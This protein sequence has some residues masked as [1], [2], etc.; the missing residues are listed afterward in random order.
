MELTV[1]EIKERIEESE[2]K[3]YALEEFESDE[4]EL[5]FTLGEI[6]KTGGNAEAILELL[7]KRKIITDK[8]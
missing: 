5:A 7:Q 2:Q 1:D 8:L 3:A 6:V 4:A